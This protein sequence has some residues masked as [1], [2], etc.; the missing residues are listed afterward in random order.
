[1][2]KSLKSFTTSEYQIQLGQI[3]EDNFDTQ[4]VIQE[5]VETGYIEVYDSSLEITGNGVYDVEDYEK[6]DVD[7]PT[8]IQPTGTINITTNGVVDVSNYANANV[9]VES[10]GGVI[11]PDLIRFSNS[12][13]T[14]Y[15]DFFD[16]V[17]TS[18]LTR[19][20]GMFEG[21]S[22]LTELDLSSFN[23]SNVTHFNSMFANCTNLVTINFGDNFDMSKS[24]TTNAVNAIYNMFVNC[25]SLSDTTLNNILKV[26]STI[27]GGSWSSTSKT[28]KYLGLTSAQATT[29][30]SLSNWSLAQ[31]SGWSKG[32]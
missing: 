25:S 22:E 5:L 1:M 18:N 20:V 24:V 14:T 31:A 12:K 28:L 29:C 21:N 8:G 4:D 16:N 10:V 9:N 2:Y 32:Y 13:C 6:A 30:T 3:L 15:S 27:T 26:I 23:T 7:V 11:L 19:C 17:D